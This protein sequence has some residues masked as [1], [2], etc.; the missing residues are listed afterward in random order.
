MASVVLVDVVVA[1][2]GNVPLPD[3]S[4]PQPTTASG[5]AMSTTDITSTRFI[6]GMVD[7]HPRFG[8]GAP[9]LRR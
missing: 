8:R 6:A 7:G 5:A 1:I 4:E 3:S 2:G 9:N